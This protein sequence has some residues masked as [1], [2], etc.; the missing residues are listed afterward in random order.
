MGLNKLLGAIEKQKC[1]PWHACSLA[2]FRNYYTMFH[3]GRN[4]I[5]V[6]KIDRDFYQT[7]SNKRLVDKVLP[8]PK[9]RC[10]MHMNIRD[11]KDYYKK[12]YN[13]ESRREVERRGDGFYQTLLVRGLVDKVLP[14]PKYK[15]WKNMGLD[16]FKEYYK[17]RYDGKSRGEVRRKDLSFYRILY[18]K[19]LLDQVLPKSKYNHWK[20]MD[21][22]DFK[23][24]YKEH[25]NGMSRREVRG[26]DLSFYNILYKKGLVDQIL[27]KLNSINQNSY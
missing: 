24:Y 27:P 5:Q 21:I 20:F 23:E 25:H 2:D 18:K 15:Y 7:L 4:K 3:E 12:H 22:D 11:F 8:R 16:E 9:Y 26:K 10:W 13:G 17:E 19:R 6:S 1:L 14:R